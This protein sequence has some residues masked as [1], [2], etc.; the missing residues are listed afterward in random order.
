MAQGESDRRSHLA[1]GFDY[2]MG[3]YRIDYSFHAS[4]A[5]GNSLN[6][7][8]EAI[9]VGRLN[10]VYHFVNDDVLQKILGLLPYSAY[11]SGRVV[12]TAPFSLHPLQEIRCHFHLQ[13]PLPGID[14][15]RQSGVQER[16]MPFVHHFRALPGIAAGAHCEGNAPV[17]QRGGSL[18]PRSCL[19]QARKTARKSAEAEFVWLRRTK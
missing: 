14:E 6:S 15:R 5:S 12:A 3:A 18:P 11:I 9:A 8:R 4:A 19:K 2:V 1:M 17:V 13:L 7:A 16:L 10:E